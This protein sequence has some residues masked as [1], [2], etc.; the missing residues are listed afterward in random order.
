MIQRDKYPGP[1]R[2]V[3]HV[4]VTR[5]TEYH[6]RR[7]ICVAVRQRAAPSFIPDHGALK[8][9]LDGHVNL[10]TLLPLAGPPKLGTRIYFANEEG[11]ILTSP[12]IAIVRP[13]KK[14]VATYPPE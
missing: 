7:G 12:V 10:G 2:R 3:H 1:E 14:V 8:M 5:N 4:Y 6:V 11:D 9:R 13:P